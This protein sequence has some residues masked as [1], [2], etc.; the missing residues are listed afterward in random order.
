YQG[1]GFLAEQDAQNWLR[2]DTFSDGRKLYAFAAVTVDG[3]STQKFK[4]AIAG[5][6]A[7]FLQMVRAGD[8]WTMKYSTDGTTWVTAGSFTHAMTVSATGVFASNSSNAN[9]FTALV[10]YFET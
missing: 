1:Q 6:V 2:Y 9:G 10:D 4:V 8:V 7:P 5:N 3:V